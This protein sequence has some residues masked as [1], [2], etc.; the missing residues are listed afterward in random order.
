MAEPAG[1]AADPGTSAREALRRAREAVEPVMRLAVDTLPGRIRT[2]AAYH[3]GWGEV[4]REPGAEPDKEGDG[5]AAEIGGSGGKLLRPG[6]VLA[7]ATA[8]AGPAAVAAAIG[9]ARSSGGVAA[10]SSSGPSPG[11]PPGLSTATVAGAGRTL[12]A[13][14]AAVELA[15]NFTLLHDDVIDRDRTR[16]HRPTA[17]TVFGAENAI[18][19]G[20]AMLALALRLVGGEAAERLAECVIEICD[21]QYEDCAFEQRDDVTLDECLAMAGKK[22]GALLGCACALGAL[23]VRAEPAAVAALDAFGRELG[24][25]FQ[26]TDDLLGIWGDP[27]ATGKPVGSDLAARKKSLPVVAALSARSAAA[28]DLAGLYALTRDFTEPELRHAA[29]AVD[30]AGGRA[31][32]AAEASARVAKAHAHLGKAP[33]VHQAAVRDLRAIADLI[34]GR[35]F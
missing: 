5:S 30:R 8:V 34:T 33:G 2:I 10:A 27:A 35:T 17:W 22:T 3:L 19:T 1:V 7:A 31:W 14:A 12:L 9:A 26:L 32:A 20:D 25:A 11:R 4:G 24:M 23:A 6:L 21:G 18:L 15:H 13:T 29:D 28:A 16:R